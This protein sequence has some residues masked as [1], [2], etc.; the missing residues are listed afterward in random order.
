MAHVAWGDSWRVEN[1]KRLRSAGL[2]LGPMIR[3]LSFLC[4]HQVQ[5]VDNT[6]VF[7]VGDDTLDTIVGDRKALIL[8]HMWALQK[9]TPAP[10]LKARLFA[11]EQYVI[12]EHKLDRS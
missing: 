8:G 10:K 5:H 11:G 3:W 9:G 12:P 1:E 4:Q 2:R 6:V 7:V